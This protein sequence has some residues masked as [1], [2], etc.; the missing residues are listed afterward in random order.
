MSFRMNILVGLW[1]RL[2]SEMNA[3]D[4]SLDQREWR[5]VGLL[6]GYAPMSLLGLAREAKVD[7]SQASRSVSGLIERGL[8]RRESD[9]SDGRGVQL[10]LTPEGR[11]LYR[12]VFA[13]AVKRNEDLMSVLSPKERAVLEEALARLTAHAQDTL[14]R[15]RGSRPGSGR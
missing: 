4:F 13:R 2:A 8:V 6:G 11:A 5:I 9:T 3:R 12:K 1:T 14:A 7:K 15:V 10:S